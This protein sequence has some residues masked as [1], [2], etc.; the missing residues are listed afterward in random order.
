MQAKNQA[1]SSLKHIVYNMQYN[2]ALIFLITTKNILMMKLRFTYS[3]TVI[4]LLFCLCYVPFGYANSD[5]A[6]QQNKLEQIRKN[7]NQVENILDKDKSKRGMLQRDL[8][9]LDK[10]IAQLSKEISHT[11]AL[12]K[13]HK[14]TLKTL[15]SDLKALEKSLRAQ[16]EVLSRQIKT[17][18]MMG[19]HETAKLLLNQQNTLEMSQALVFYRYLNKTRS[20]QILE[21]NLLVQEKTSLKDSITDKTLKLAELKNDQHRQR[22][23]FSAN[24]SKRNNLIAQLNN[25]IV[26]NEDTLT[27]LQSHRKKIES[28]L[29]SLGEVLA[30]IPSKPA[31]VKPFS[32]LKGRLPW[33][34]KGPII[35][36]F[37]TKKARSD[38]KWNGVVLA[39]NY[40]EAVHAINRGR[41][42]FPDWLQGYG[43]IIILDHGSSYMSLYGYN[44]TLLK[45][46]GEW[47]NQG[48]VIATVG[49]SGGQKKSGLYFEIRKQ[50]KPVNPKK[51]CSGKYTHYA[52]G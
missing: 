47:V 20:H 4:Y 49:D 12:I 48:D 2:S 50:G 8:K 17:A 7:I 40:G 39:K 6:L 14:S 31:G 3:K 46:P 13:K 22:N 21:Y 51:W 11:K 10:K 44:Q 42:I 30:D 27:S 34:V 19:Q 1:L 35:N 16:K 26:S 45:E 28:L 41:V 25:K 15:K 37:G 52:A 9:S 23:R 18:Y 5:K 33:P 36:Q 43:F 24:R 32:T 38:L 29:I